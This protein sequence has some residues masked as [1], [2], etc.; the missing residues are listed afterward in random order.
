MVVEDSTVGI[1]AAVTT[2]AE[3]IGAVAVQGF[4]VMAG[5]AGLSTLVATTDTVMHIL[6]IVTCAMTRI[7]AIIGLPIPATEA[8]TGSQEL[9]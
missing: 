4:T 5:T 9:W 6:T 8:E 7:M 2:E 3:D 1:R